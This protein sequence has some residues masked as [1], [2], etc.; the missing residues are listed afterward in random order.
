M[1]RSHRRVHAITWTILG[2][3]VIAALVVSLFARPRVVGPH[4]AA[5]TEGS[6]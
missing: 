6:R 4:A 1:T 2:P 3:L 5:G